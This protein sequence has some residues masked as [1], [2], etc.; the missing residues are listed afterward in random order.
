MTNRPPIPEQIA[1]EVRQRCGF[2]CIACGSPVYEYHH[3]V[4]WVQ[5]LEHRADNLVLLCPTH[6]AEAT[7]GML[8]RE[9]ITALEQAR[10][11]TASSPHRIH[12]HGETCTFYFGKSD[13]KCSEKDGR[14]CAIVIDN[15]EM[16]GCSFNSGAILLRMLIAD[17]YQN[18]I[19]I[20]NDGDIRYVPDYWDIKWV[21]RRLT[22]RDGPR[23]IRLD[24][25]FRPP[26]E[27]LVHRGLFLWNGVGIQVAPH[28][29][30]VLNNGSVISFE[31]ETT[32]KS[33]SHSQR[34]SIGMAFG[35][36]SE[37]V[38]DQAGVVMTRL[39]R[40]VG[41]DLFGQVEDPCR[42]KP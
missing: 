23:R 37:E 26:N 41:H 29:T 42:S 32:E 28:G 3:I 35:K 19:L 11:R 25:E 20:C 40:F 22:L 7:V 34:R 13:W 8:S 15:T 4:P 27:V 9:A 21:G 38:R 2:A 16:L 24:I 18:L 5:C 36:L 30:K 14:F 1:R 10:H 17:E 31:G 33:E 39:N 12:Y 6:H